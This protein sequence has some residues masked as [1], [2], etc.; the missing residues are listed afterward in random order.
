MTWNGWNCLEMAGIGNGWSRV[1]PFIFLIIRDQ[2]K[3]RRRKHI[4][5]KQNSILL[6][7]KGQSIICKEISPGSA[8]DRS[9][10]AV[11]SQKDQ[12]VVTGDNIQESAYLADIIN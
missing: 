7:Q 9:T 1:R 2:R 3:K 11:D 12:R 6:M 5:G 8:L 10:M 4:V